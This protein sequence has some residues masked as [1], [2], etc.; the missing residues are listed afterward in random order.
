MDSKINNQ[1][2]SLNRVNTPVEDREPKTKIKC[3]GQLLIFAMICFIA[4]QY[5]IYTYEIMWKTT[6]SI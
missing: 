2:E 4:F 3:Y 5:Y 6:T 1:S